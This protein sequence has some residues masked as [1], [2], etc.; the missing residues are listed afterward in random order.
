MP[1][2]PERKGLATKGLHSTGSSLT[3]CVK[4]ETSHVA[5]ELAE[6]QSMEKSLPMRT[7]A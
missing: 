7:S 1:F 5:M 3:L 6:S 2:A 4:E